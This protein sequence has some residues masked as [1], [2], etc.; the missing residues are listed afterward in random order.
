MQDA[1]PDGM[2]AATVALY[3]EA[4][5]LFDADGDGAINAAELKEMMGK[6]QFECTDA[7]VQQVIDSLDAKDKGGVD[8]MEMLADM[9]KPFSKKQTEADPD[10]ELKA[11]FKLFSNAEGFISSK[12]IG[13]VMTGL[14]ESLTA[15]EVT[16]MIAQ[17][18]TD[19]FIDFDAFKKLMAIRPRVD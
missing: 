18:T 5:P 4:F 8:F 1:V 7:E 6:M 14:G 13:D 9:N 15:A 17:V 12:E 10:F 16:E 2:D 11:A 3:K 19:A